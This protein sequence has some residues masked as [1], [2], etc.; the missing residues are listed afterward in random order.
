M[1]ISKKAFIGSGAFSAPEPGAKIVAWV[2]SNQRSGS[3]TVW[4]TLASG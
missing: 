3:R 4:I 1:T 2:E